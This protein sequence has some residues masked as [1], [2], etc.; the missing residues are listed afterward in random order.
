MK[1]LIVNADD[2]GLH[3][4]INIGIIAGHVN[5]CITSTSLMAGGG[6][7]EHA[8]YLAKASPQLG[9]GVHLTLVGC[10]PVSKPQE[11]PTLVDSN[12]LLPEKY[13]LFLR[14]FIL[15]KVSLKDIH[16]EFRAQVKKV[17][18]AGLPITHLDS[19]QHMHVVPGIIDIAIEVANEFDIKAMRIPD[20]SLLFIGGAKATGGRLVGRTGLSVLASLARRKAMKKG[21]VTP[22]NFF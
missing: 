9:I 16:R 7:F 18:E 21:L 11:V 4:N 8:V 22:K 14:Q 15:G 2:F 19:H 5:G 17:L 10:R 12:G 1:Q 6:A 3:E 13:P 20:E